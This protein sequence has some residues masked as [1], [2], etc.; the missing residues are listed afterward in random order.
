MLRVT[1]I[2]NEQKK[3][4]ALHEQKMSLKVCSVLNVAI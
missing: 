2:A 4:S 3:D 1:V